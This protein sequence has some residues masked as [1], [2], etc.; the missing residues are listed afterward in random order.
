MEEKPV[1]HVSVRDVDAEAA[2]DLRVVA[3]ELD[4]SMAEAVRRLL[5]GWARLNRTHPE[6]ARHMLAPVD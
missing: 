6:T 4:L 2:R 5:L 3:A 1:V